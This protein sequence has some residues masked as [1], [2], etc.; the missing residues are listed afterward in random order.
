[1][2]VIAFFFIIFIFRHISG[3]YIDVFP[4]NRFISLRRNCN[5]LY[6]L[7]PNT[8]S[9]LARFKVEYNSLLE[10]SS[11]SGSISDVERIKELKVI[12]DCVEALEKIDNDLAL[13][14]EHENGADEGLKKTAQ[15]FTQ[16]FL[17]C[18]IQLETQLNNLLK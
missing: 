6:A 14:A 16:E 4:T 18:K 5:K 2:L 10:T 12:F 9:V 8:D 1:M 13:F 17:M 11:E 15:I 7:S 3:L